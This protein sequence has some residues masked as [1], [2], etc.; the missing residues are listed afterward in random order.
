MLYFSGFTYMTGK[1][2]SFLAILS[3]SLQGPLCS[4]LSFPLTLDPYAS[5][6][7]AQPGPGLW[8]TVRTRV[9]VIKQSMST[10][11]ETA[12]LGE[13]LG[14]FPAVQCT[15]IGSVAVGKPLSLSGPDATIGPFR[16]EWPTAQLLQWSRRQPHPP[17]SFLAFPPLPQRSERTEERLCAIV[18][19]AR[20]LPSG[21]L[22]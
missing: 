19:S 5:P 20:G 16:T 11:G 2:H 7:G 10:S 18:G 13:K 17:R 8:L 15:P 3:T 21:I 6:C 4:S 1:N 9:C 12:S 22:S 14:L